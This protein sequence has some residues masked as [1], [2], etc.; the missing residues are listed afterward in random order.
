M[1]AKKKGNMLGIK[2]LNKKGKFEIIGLLLCK[3][4][5]KWCS[6]R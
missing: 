1:V 4:S 2:R 3:I 6:K 5:R